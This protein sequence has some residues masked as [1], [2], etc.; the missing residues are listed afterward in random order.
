M[1]YGP[2]KTGIKRYAYEIRIIYV[3]EQLVYYIT[4]AWT[5]VQFMYE[6]IYIYSKM[7]GYWIIQDYLVDKWLYIV[8]I[9]YSVK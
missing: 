9:I 7:G 1:N 6:H 2:V 8:Q 3:V 5:M 4:C